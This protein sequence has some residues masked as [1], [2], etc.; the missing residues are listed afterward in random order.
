MYYWMQPLAL[1]P[2]QHMSFD[3]AAVLIRLCSTYMLRRIDGLMLL[4]LLLTEKQSTINPNM[5]RVTV[6]MTEG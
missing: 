1:L 4:L 5:K 6:D 3:Q 2:Q